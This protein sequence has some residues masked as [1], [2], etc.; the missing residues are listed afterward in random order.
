MNPRII[1]I[2]Y[3]QNHKFLLRF[4]NDELKIFNLKPYLQYPVYQALEDETFCAKATVF[5]GTIKWDEVI[6]FDPDTLYMESVPNEDVE[7]TS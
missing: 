1:A 7:M 5:N 2:E 4:S 3:L 6:D